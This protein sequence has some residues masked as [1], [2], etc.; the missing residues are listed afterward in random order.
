M[1]QTSLSGEGLG[2]LESGMLPSPQPVAQ[3][4][5]RCEI[6]DS[7]VT[8]CRP[9]PASF[10]ATRCATKAS[11]APTTARPSRL[12]LEGVSQVE[13]CGLIQVGTASAHSS[14]SAC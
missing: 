9:S 13:W 12:I 1:A 3:P 4:F 10:V 5:A 8:A 2:G 6:K 7:L 11:N 14:S